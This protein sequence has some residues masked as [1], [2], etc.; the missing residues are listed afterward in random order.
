LGI[1]GGIVG[2]VFV[3]IGVFIY[4]TVD[5][6]SRRVPLEIQAYPGAEDWGM[7]DRGPQLRSV[8]FR[9]PGATPEQVA[10][11]YNQ[12]LNQFYG[13]N[14]ETCV[15]RPATGNY[16]AFEAGTSLLP[17]E[18]ICMFDR[19]YWNATQ[20]TQITIQPG[21]FN[22]DPALNTEGYTVVEHFQQWN[23]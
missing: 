23:P 9:I 11:Y 2:I 13:N 21:V 19:S 5:Q 1:I 4:L 18:Y 14:D 12:Q 6:G 17:Y 10:E 22:E 15:R 16:Q 8:F 20:F 3:F 7:R